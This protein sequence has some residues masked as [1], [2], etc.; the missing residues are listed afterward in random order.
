MPK[1]LKDLFRLQGKG[2]DGYL[3]IRAQNS[4]NLI[5]HQKIRDSPRKDLH[6][7]PRSKFQNP[8]F[9]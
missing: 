1:T 3:T 8:G 2:P 4:N 7:L 9:S 6:K 5:D